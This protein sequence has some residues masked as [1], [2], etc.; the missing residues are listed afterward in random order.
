MKTE[1]LNKDEINVLKIESLTRKQQ[2][3]YICISILEREN[4]MSN[5]GM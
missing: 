2:E 1:E 3:V 5:E 4:E